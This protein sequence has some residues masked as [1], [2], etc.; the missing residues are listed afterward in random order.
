[1]ADRGVKCRV[2]PYF[3]QVLQLAATEVTGVTFLSCF[4][5]QNTDLALIGGITPRLE[6]EQLT[7]MFV[8]RSTACEDIKRNIWCI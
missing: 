6:R 8:Q 7:S 3:I 1:M 2:H 5:G 4:A